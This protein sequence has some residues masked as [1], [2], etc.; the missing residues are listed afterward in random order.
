M[1]NLLA[2]YIPL[3]RKCLFLISWQVYRHRTIIKL[4]VFLKGLETILNGEAYDKIRG[5]QKPG[6]GSLWR[7]LRGIN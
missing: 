6:P 5:N 4:Y 2:L 3:H 7:V 1:K